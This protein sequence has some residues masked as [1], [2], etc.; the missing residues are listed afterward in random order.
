MARSPQADTPSK[1]EAGPD[2]ADAETGG[3]GGGGILDGL[4]DLLNNLGKS[5]QKET[6]DS[7]VKPDAENKQINP[8]DLGKAIGQKTL[9]EISRRTG[10]S[11]Q[12]LLDK[13]S[14]VLPGVVDK[15]TPDGRVPTNKEVAKQISDS[16]W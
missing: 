8:T 1:R 10:L 6:A 9:S 3:K 11:E 15:L 13:L 2:S 4:G 5:G 12:E 14:S 7:W 16:P